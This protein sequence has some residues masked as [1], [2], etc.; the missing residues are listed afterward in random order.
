MEFWTR[1]R[2]KKRFGGGCCHTSILGRK[3]TM[4]HDEAECSALTTRE[5]PKLLSACGAPTALL[6]VHVSNAIASSN[7]MTHYWFHHFVVFF[8]MRQCRLDLGKMMALRWKTNGKRTANKWSKR[9]ANSVSCKLNM[10]HIERSLY[11]YLI[12]IVALKKARKLMNISEHFC[13]VFG[14]RSSMHTNSIINLLDW[15][16]L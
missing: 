6:R 7:A 2:R 13:C 1:E 14:S 4:V 3:L 12:F 15:S 10:R 5:H 16:G 9:V 8:H 11:A